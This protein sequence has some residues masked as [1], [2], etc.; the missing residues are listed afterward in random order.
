MLRIRH[1]ALEPTIRYDWVY[2]Y[3]N[4]PGYLIRGFRSAALGGDFTD[5]FFDLRNLRIGLLL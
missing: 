3:M 2:C 5:F 1:I 4:Y